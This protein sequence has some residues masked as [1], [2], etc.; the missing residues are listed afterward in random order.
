[1]RPILHRPLV[2]VLAIGMVAGCH[3]A[4]PSF[5]PGN[6]RSASDC[7]AVIARVRAD[8]NV[9]TAPRAGSIGIVIPP[10]PAPPQAH[11]H[12]AELWVPVDERGRVRVSDVRISG[13]PDVDYAREIKHAA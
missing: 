2:L 9:R 3:R 12:T 5:G 4:P 13:M 7:A 10:V 8:T 11:G 6:L 1:M